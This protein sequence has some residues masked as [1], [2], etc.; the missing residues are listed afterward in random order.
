MKGIKKS[1][2]NNKLTAVTVSADKM[3]RVNAPLELP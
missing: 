3:G 2:T 1:N